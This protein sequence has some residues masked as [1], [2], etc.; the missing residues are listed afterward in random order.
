MKAICVTPQRKLEARDVPEPTK[1]APGHVLI[2]MQACAINHGDKTFLQ[3]PSAAG[4]ARW[5][6][7]YD[8]WGASGVG[9]VID[10]G[11]GVPAELLGKHVALYRSLCRTPESIGLWSELAHMPYR[12]CLILP[13][14]VSARDYCGSL[15]NAMTAYAFLEEI[16]EAGHKAVIVTAGTSAT[17]RA[18]VTLARIRDIS[19]IIL[20]RTEQAADSLRGS[21]AAHVIVTKHGFA[22]TLGALAIQ[23][24]AT[25]V[26][27]GV[28]GELLTTIS[29]EL[30]MNTTVYFYGF[31]GGTIPISIPPALF[32]KK[33]LTLKRFSN[34]DSQTVRDNDR[35]ISA[36]NA[37]AD[38]I[39]EQAFRTKIGREF[40][41][42]QIEQAISYVS[43][44]GRK[45]V[46]VL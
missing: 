6:G 44:E 20:V 29:P 41:L 28:G 34:F 37:L 1:A 38:V 39:H 27:E 42:D 22:D 45:A 36:L 12:T 3:T 35:L 4:D 23:L 13:E 18:L 24:K 2:D 16:I 7:K 8:V 46:L 10:I 14:H 26:F 32:M 30:P 43:Q 9:R 19:T 11:A 17:G 15:V 31:L 21:G 40:Q 33:N 25:A 5:T